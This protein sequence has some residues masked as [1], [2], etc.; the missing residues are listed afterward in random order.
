MKDKESLKKNHQGN[1]V[2]VK[3]TPSSWGAN[4][5]LFLKEGIGTA[6]S[7]LLIVAVHDLKSTVCRCVLMAEC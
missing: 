5:I 1:N 3:K 4:T 7:E 6:V 2:K